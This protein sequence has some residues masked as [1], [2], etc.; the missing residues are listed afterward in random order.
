MAGGVLLGIFG[1]IFCGVS[2]WVLFQK[3]TQLAI[4]TLK[5]AYVTELEQSYLEP[6]TKQ[7]VV[8]EV[9]KLIADMEDGKYENWQSAAIMQR[10]QRLP[11]VQWGELQA[12]QLFIEKTN[13]QEKLNSS[14]NSLVWNGRLRTDWPH[15]L[16]SRMFWNLFISLIPV[17]RADFH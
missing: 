5:G 1:F 14:S 6:E 2:T 3:R 16:T 15:P 4:R 10:L 13:S 17:M 9:Q 12:V 8:A 7:A 11:V